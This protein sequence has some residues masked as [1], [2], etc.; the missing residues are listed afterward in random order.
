MKTREAEEGDISITEA[1]QAVTRGDRVEFNVHGYWESMVGGTRLESLLD[2][3]FRLK[4]RGRISVLASNYVHSMNPT[5]TLV[6]FGVDVVED[7]VQH[8]LGSIKS[9][10]LN[11]GHLAE[12][13][14][15]SVRF[16]IGPDQYDER[17][18]NREMV[19]KS[20]IGDQT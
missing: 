14:T 7:F 5:R 19:S 18:K 9:D 11:D 4:S 1:L 13:V 17:V 6:S 16:F 2:A 3:R 20:K 10:Q 12:K 8:L 15:D